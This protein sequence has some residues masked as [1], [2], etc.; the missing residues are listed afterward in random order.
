M[1]DEWIV[2]VKL[3]VRWFTQKVMDN[4]QKRKIDVQSSKA[5]VIHLVWISE[6]RLLCWQILFKMLISY[7]ETLLSTTTAFYLCHSSDKH[8]V[9]IIVHW[10]FGGNSKAVELETK[11]EKRW[12]SIAQNFWEHSTWVKLLWEYK[13]DSNQFFCG[14]NTFVAFPRSILLQLLTSI[15]QIWRPLTWPAFAKAGFITLLFGPVE[16]VPQSTC[17]ITKIKLQ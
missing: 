4:L 12:Q 11:S 2:A 1:T 14:E 10:L 16:V 6:S 9:L 17:E 15:R 8:R 7:R 13:F 5:R 3:Y